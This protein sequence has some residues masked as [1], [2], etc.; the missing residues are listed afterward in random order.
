MIPAWAAAI[1]SS[2]AAGSALAGHSA[3]ISRSAASSRP[4]RMSLRR[5]SALKKPPKWW[6]WVPASLGPRAASSTSRH[7]SR[8][9]TRRTSMSSFSPGSRSRSGRVASS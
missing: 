7:V 1:S 3:L 5:Q 2:R 6:T 9:L 4:H 8:G